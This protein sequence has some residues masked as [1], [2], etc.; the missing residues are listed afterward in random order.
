MTYAGVPFWSGCWGSRRASRVS[1]SL[2]TI[3]WLRVAAEIVGRKKEM[4]EYILKKR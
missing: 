2:A 1:F 4:E 3:C